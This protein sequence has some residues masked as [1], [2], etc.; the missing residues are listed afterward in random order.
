MNIT[1]LKKEYLKS[2]Q[3][4]DLLVAD[5]LDQNKADD[6]VTIDLRG[7]SLIADSMIIASGSSDRFLK[8]LAEKL[9][10]FLHSQGYRSVHIEGGDACDWVL[11]DGSDVI[12]HLFKPEVRH[13]YN[14]E[15]IWGG[16]PLASDKRSA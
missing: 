1:K 10:A 9:K 6:I 4:L 12:V 16:P 5:F 8:A 13:Y 3:S 14:L 11:V 7:K 15:K 2:S